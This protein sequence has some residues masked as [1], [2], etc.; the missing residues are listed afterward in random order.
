M[1]VRHD[2]DR[3]TVRQ[4]RL[5]A[6]F[7]EAERV[8]IVERFRKLDRRLKRF[9]ADAVDMQLSVKGRDS[10]EQ[11]VVLDTRIAGLD[12]FV[13]TS[14]EPVLKDALNDVR[15]EIWRTVD[16]AVNKRTTNSRRR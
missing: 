6:G 12:R 7:A 11:Q 2:G 9:D 3:A 10:N 15:D 1:G 4:L 13:V 14:R 5:G 16:D 8:D